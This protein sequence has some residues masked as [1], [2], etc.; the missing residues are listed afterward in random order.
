MP[1]HEILAVADTV[2][3]RPDRDPVLALGG[4]ER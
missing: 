3:V 4:A 2:L 1:A